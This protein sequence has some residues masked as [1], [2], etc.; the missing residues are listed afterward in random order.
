[1]STAQNAV[2]GRGRQ[3]FRNDPRPRRRQRHR[4]GNPAVFGRPRRYFHRDAAKLTPW[5]R[6][7]R[8]RD[9]RAGWRYHPRYP[10][11]RRR[12]DRRSRRP[13][14]LRREQLEAGIAEA[15]DPAGFGLLAL[16]RRG[17]TLR[18]RV[19]GQDPS[20]GYR[21]VLEPAHFLGRDAAHVV[22]DDSAPW[23]HGTAVS[24]E[25]SEA[26]HSVRA[27]LRPPRGIIPCRSP[28]TARPSSAAPSSTARSM[29]NH[30]RA[31]CSASSRTA[32]RATAS[33]TSTSMA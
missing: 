31:S 6:Q 2:I 5:R 19:P 12:G 3:W 11:R 18:W 23:P 13:A 9:H 10:R 27:S 17:C 25:A 33:P 29:W 32:M 28:S 30:G 7:P 26:P 8:R 1:M 22:P 14:D 15:E 4:Q 21:L 20:P 24:F 16:S